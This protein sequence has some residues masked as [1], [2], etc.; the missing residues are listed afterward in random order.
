MPETE[1]TPHEND[2][3]SIE[4]GPDEIYRRI[5][6][7][8][9][10]LSLPNDWTVLV[11]RRR[12]PD[13]GFS[14]DFKGTEARLFTPTRDMP[15]GPSAASETG[16]F[17]DVVGTTVAHVANFIRRAL[18]NTSAPAGKM[19]PEFRAAR[20]AFIE[21]LLDVGEKTDNPNLLIDRAEAFFNGGSNT[22]VDIYVIIDVIDSLHSLSRRLQDPSASE[23]TN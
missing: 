15:L 9:E 8:M 10:E 12:N 3:S 16:V 1:P 4:I 6:A 21:Q 14:S 20:N 11:G 7:A 17:R 19:T 23:A 5:R 13:K 2:T 22:P 18:H